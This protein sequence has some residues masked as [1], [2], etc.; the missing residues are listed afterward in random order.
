MRRSIAFLTFAALMWATWGRS[1]VDKRPSG[2]FPD[3]AIVPEALPP[4]PVLARYL[5][6]FRMEGAWQ[7]KSSNAWVFGYSAM[8]AHTDGRLL[9]FNDSGHTLMFSPPG[10]KP[11]KARE[12]RIRF[13]DP[14]HT[15]AGRDVESVAYDPANRRYWLGMEGLNVVTRLSA[16]LKETGRVA[17]AGMAHW[18]LNTGAEA[19]TRLPDGRFIA[20]REVPPSLGEARLHDALLFSGDPVQHPDA[21]RF[22][23]D[24]PDNFSAVDMA[25]LPDG[26]ALI[27]MRRLLWPMPLRFAGR[28]VIADTARIRPGKVWPSATLASLAS[29]LPVDN[30]EAIA[31]VPQPD[32]RI[33]VWLMS[34]D[35]AMR[36]L[37]RTLLWKLSVDPAKLPWPR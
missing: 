15:K 24:G 20:I 27:L 18:G 16:N 22:Q 5:G 28:I 3:L 19:M 33:T 13:K 30:F 29:V 25:L 14:I 17:P 34:D 1:P 4:G 8:V 21:A 36:V 37:Q 23:F 6:P 35:N 11:S 2:N 32:G 12:K 10:A 26:R 9:A 31:A 7:I